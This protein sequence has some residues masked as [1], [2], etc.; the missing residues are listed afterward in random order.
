MFNIFQQFFNKT[1]NTVDLTNTLIPAILTLSTAP[2]TTPIILLLLFIIILISAI[3]KRGYITTTINHV[4]KCHLLHVAIRIINTHVHISQTYS[5]PLTK[6]Y[7]LAIIIT[8][9][10]TYFFQKTPFYQ[11]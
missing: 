7:N 5:K 4:F 9:H 8:V 10:D 1:F 6:R 3:R 11:H 2:T